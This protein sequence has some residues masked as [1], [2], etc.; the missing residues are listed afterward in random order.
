MFTFVGRVTT[1]HPW[2]VCLTWLVVGVALTL[3]APRWDRQTLD[4]D[5]HF[6]P[7]DC[8]SVRGFHLLE[9]A[10]PQDVYA[11]RLIVV[12][13]RARE[14]LRPDD[15]I[16]VDDLVSDLVRLREQEPDLQLRKIVSQRDAFIGKRLVSD[17]GQCTL[18]QIALDT[19]YLA[20]QTKKT[21]DRIN[22]LVRDRLEYVANAPDVHLSGPAG[23]GRDLVTASG[24]SL[25]STTLATVALVVVVLLCVYRSPLLALVPLL[26]IAV[27]VWVA[28]EILAL[29]TLLPGFY[30]VN[31][32]AIFAVVM[33]WGAGTDYCLFLISR[34]REELA[35]GLP[36]GEALTAALRGVGGALTASAA[37]VI[38]GLGLMATAEFAKVRCGGPAIA[39]S[40]A[41]ALVASLTLTPALLRLLGHVAFWPVRV[42]ASGGK[43]WDTLSHV[44]ARR[45]LL[46]GSLAAL[47]L[48]P[49]A[50]L[51]LSVQSSYRAT[52]ELAPTASSVRGLQ[53][54]QRHFTEGELGPV[55]VLLESSQDWDTPRGRRVLNLLSTGFATLP[56]VAEVR[57]LTRPLGKPIEDMP[58]PP[59]ARKNIRGSL[60]TAVWKRAAQG[61]SDQI[62]KQAR[63]FYLS[64]A[65]EKYV[66]RLDVVLRTDP[67]DPRSVDTLKL[68]QIWLDDELPL[69][70]GHPVRA[71]CYG[72]TVSARDLATV[73]ERDR[74]RINL[75]VLVGIAVILLALVR[76]PVLALYLL[77]TVLFSY[78]ATLGATTLLAHGWHG[79]PLGEIDWRVP[80][81][82][83]TILIAVGEDY[84]ILLLSRALEERKRHGGVEGMRRALAA[85]G[86]TITS[87]GLIMAGTFATLVLAGLNTLV[88]V[89][90]A[91][92]FG[93]L[94]D[95][96]VVRPI[97][98]PA[99][100]LWWWRDEAREPE[101]QAE[102]VV[103]S[104]AA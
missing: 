44:L 7:A 68:L 21:V 47:L 63:A 82:L 6:L 103:M 102:E 39:V 50:I 40:L 20:L 48:L 32:S 69:L 14:P 1:R 55:T 4:D 99:F 45:P 35:R 101:A 22:T 89:G 80:F 8:P 13:K 92:A 98:V 37:T 15:L 33:L 65:N 17:D 30:L 9:Q 26:T 62:V 16:L 51:G 93:V 57:S 2:L 3:V 84:N 53:A 43:L 81:F 90:F 70:A 18:I 91:L 95:T 75:L 19:P 46:F 88:Q 54:I 25:D 60:F 31:V 11:S 10:F 24:Q 87:C 23:V 83:F 29:L 85:T 71:E 56:N 49:L 28:L 72:V 5:I 59:P 42:K 77:A 79:R 12:V 74:G 38:C 86:G 104:R 41:V 100:T 96:F 52:A 64:Q 73:T 78:Y 97:L 76:D 36:R 61:V 66:A 94:L 27:A 34:Y 67:F 58:D